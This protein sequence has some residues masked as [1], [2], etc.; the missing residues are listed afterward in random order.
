MDRPGDHFF[1]G[2]ALAE[3]EDRMRTVGGLGDDAVE[4]LHL[5]GTADE[6]AIPLFGFEFLAENTIFGFK[7]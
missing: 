1:A 6:A 7:F 2:A 4:L 3:N 5:W